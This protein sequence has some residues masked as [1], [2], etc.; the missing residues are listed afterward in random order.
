MSSNMS[1]EDL[2]P[3]EWLINNEHLQNLSTI[4]EKYSEP[5]E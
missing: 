1:V 5:V 3:W 4:I 2:V